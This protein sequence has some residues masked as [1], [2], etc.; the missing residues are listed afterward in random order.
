MILLV[1]VLVLISDDDE[2]DIPETTEAIIMPDSPYPVDDDTIDNNNSN[3]RINNGNGSNE[4]ESPAD[5]TLSFKSLTYTDDRRR[6]AEDRAQQAR[7][8]AAVIK[9]EEDA[10]LQSESLS[11]DQLARVEERRIAAAAI[12]SSTGA[13]STTSSAPS[14][15]SL[16][17]KRPSAINLAA[18]RAASS[19]A[20]SSTIAASVLSTSLMGKPEDN[21]PMTPMTRP[22]TVDDSKVSYS[23]TSLPSY[24][25]HTNDGMEC[26]EM[27]IRCERV[28]RV[29]L[30]V[31]VSIIDQLAKD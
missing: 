11:F 29:C 20:I 14:Q 26:N 19:S 12:L 17:R 8:H 16:A 7:D 4:P 30:V 3:S 15:S 18:A 28:P 27:L 24:C 6:S 10:V 23:F 31:V 5:T 25:L 21:S 9:R 13:T 2:P 1:D 22:T